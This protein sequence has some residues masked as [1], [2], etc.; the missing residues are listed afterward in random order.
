ML[1]TKHDTCNNAEQ[2]FNSDNLPQKTKQ[3]V[4]NCHKLNVL[5]NNFNK[6][7]KSKININLSLQRVHMNRKH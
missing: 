5:F 3:E 6:L 1:F 2:N 7:V 4:T